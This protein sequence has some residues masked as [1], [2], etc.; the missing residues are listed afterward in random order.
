MKE[1]AGVF[2]KD[3]TNLKKIMRVRS[4]K[5]YVIAVLVA[6]AIVAYIVIPII[7]R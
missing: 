4:F 6:L 5:M 2:S 3:S 1:Q 7:V